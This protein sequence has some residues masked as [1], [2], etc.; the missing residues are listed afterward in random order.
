MLSSLIKKC[1]KCSIYLLYIYIYEVT[2]WY[3]HIL[4]RYLVKNINTILILIKEFQIIN[5]KY[6][7]KFIIKLS[8]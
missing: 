5:F 4:Y 1:Y 6:M 7:I 8:K 3:K 2:E